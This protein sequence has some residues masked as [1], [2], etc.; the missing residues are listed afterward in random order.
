MNTPKIAARFLRVV[1]GLLV[2]LGLVHI[3]ATPH[4]PD[5]L[6]G[7]PSVVFARAVGPTLL[8]HVLVG[9]LLIPLGYTTWLAAAARVRGEPWAIRVLILNT[10]VVLTLPLS[11]VVFMR[12]AEFYTAP[13]FVTG[14]G[15]VAIISLM[16]IGA[17]FLLMR[18]QGMQ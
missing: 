5:L 14:A 8:N 12:R 6:G 15:L 7:C 4:I 3:A 17:T 16:M 11:I 18:K 13:L 1:G 9:M 2:A 10:T